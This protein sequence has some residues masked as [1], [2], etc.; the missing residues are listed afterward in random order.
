[1]RKRYWGQVS[2]EYPEAAAAGV[3]DGVDRL[4]GRDVHDEQ[5]HVDQ[6]G[7]IDGAAGRFTLR[8]AGMAH[9]VVARQAVSAL[10]QAPAE[11]A[12]DVVVLRVHHDHRLFAPRDLQ[13]VEHLVVVEAQGLV[14]HVH[15]ERGV[16]VADEGGK[17]LAEH[18]LRRVGDDEV[19]GVVHHRL[20]AGARVVVL[21]HFAQRLSPVLGGEGDDGG[22]AAEGG[23]DGSGMEVVRAHHPE[24]GLLLDVAV[25][26]DAAGQHEALLR[27]NLAGRPRQVARERHDPARPESRRRRPWCRSRSPRYRCAPP[28]REGPCR[29]SRRVSEG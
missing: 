22:G 3:A 19:E 28:G 20:G 24:G 25:A 4:A 9:R 26:V 14:G 21:D 16:A 13:H 15:L 11:P 5:G 8:D 12:N 27:V 6:R 29:F 23:G 7:E 1:M 18:L 2:P 17:L 10:E